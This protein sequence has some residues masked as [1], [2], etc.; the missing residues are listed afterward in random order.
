[1]TQPA[2]ANIRHRW[3]ASH[4]GYYA[5]TAMLW[6]GSRFLVLAYLFVGIGALYF[7]LCVPRARRASM[8]Y[9]DR[10]RPN[11]SLLRRWWQTYRHMTVFGLLLLDRAL[12]L[13]TSRHH[14]S[15]SAAGLPNLTKPAAAGEGVLM[16]TAH[17]GNAEAAAPY[18]SRMGVTRPVHL[19]MYRDPADATEKFHTRHRRLLSNVHI[20]STTD[21][22]AA[23]IKIINALRHGDVVALRADRAMQG[24]TLPSSLLGA[25]IHLPAGPFL[26]A[27]LSGAPVVHVY[28]CRLGY[29]RYL[30]RV[31]PTYRYGP[32]QPGTRDQRIACAAADFT[33]HLEEVIHLHPLQW[34][35]FY[36]L[37]ADGAQ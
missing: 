31:S 1:L 6:I 23:G 26:A 12:M 37:W 3:G 25:P 8:S 32:D 27:A 15:I 5:N 20:I 19:V 9:L 35:N 10:L 16:L 21:P 24:K 36:N 33:K 22:L 14:F 4:F 11:R 13:T 18:M 29:R 7:F 2:A 17:F 30:C 34:S 28:T